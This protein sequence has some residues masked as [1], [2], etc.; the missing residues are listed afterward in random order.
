VARF[1]VTSKQVV[2]VICMGGLEHLFAAS[3]ALRFMLVSYLMQRRPAG[4]LARTRSL[5]PQAI[6]LPAPSERIRYK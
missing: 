1:F 6:V 5:P 3:S 2:T 4:S